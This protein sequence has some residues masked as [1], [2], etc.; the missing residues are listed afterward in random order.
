MSKDSDPSRPRISG[1]SPS[2]KVRGRMPMP[3]K[4]DL[5]MRSKEVAITA[6]MPNR[7]GP[8]AAQSL[9]LPVPY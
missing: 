3:T 1:P 7:S 4:L 5:W 9:L 8:F 2:R 6:F